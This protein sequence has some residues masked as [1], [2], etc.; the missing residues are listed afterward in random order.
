MLDSANKLRPGLKTEFPEVEWEGE[1][2]NSNGLIEFSDGTT[3]QGNFQNHKLKTGTLCYPNG[4]HLSGTFSESK[5][6]IIGLFQKGVFTFSNHVKINIELSGLKVVSAVMY[7]AKGKEVYKFQGSDVSIQTKDRLYRIGFFGVTESNRSSNEDYSRETFYSFFGPFYSANKLN[8]K[9]KS[10]FFND[11]KNTLDDSKKKAKYDIADLEII[12]KHGKKNTISFE[13]KC[14]IGSFHFFVD[15]ETDFDSAVGFY[16]NPVLKMN[17]NMVIQGKDLIFVYEKKVLHVKKLKNMIMEM[18][19]KIVLGQ[20]TNNI[21]SKQDPSKVNDILRNLIRDTSVDREHK[22][23]HDTLDAEYR[24]LKEEDE[25][26]RD[27]IENLK[28]QCED[29]ENKICDLNKKIDYQNKRDHDFDYQK[30]LYVQAHDENE[31][32]NEQI[33]KMKVTMAEEEEIKNRLQNDK[34]V[35]SDENMALISKVDE[36][37]NVIRGV[38][39]E[40]AQLST[41]IKNV[42]EQMNAEKVESEKIIKD[43]EKKCLVH[44]NESMRLMDEIN[45]LQQLNSEKELKFDNERKDYEEAIESLKEDLEESEA[46]VELLENDL[47][48]Y[49]KEIEGLEDKREKLTCIIEDIELE[50]EGKCNEIADLKK[51]DEIKEKEFLKMAKSNIDMKEKVAALKNEIEDLNGII[52]TI[53]EVNAENRK[54][55]EEKEIKMNQAIEMYK[56]QEKIRNKDIEDMEQ[57]FKSKI[58]GIQYEIEKYMKICANYKTALE[59]QKDV[60]ELDYFKGS[61]EN[62]NKHGEC[63][64]KKG[65]YHFVGIYNKGVKEGKGKE[66]NN[67]IILEGTFKADLL[68]GKG[69]YIDKAT[70]KKMEGEFSNGQFLGEKM[71]INKLLYTGGIS[72]NKMNGKGYF[73]FQNNYSYEGTFCKDEVEENSKGIIINLDTGEDISVVV[74]NGR[75]IEEDTKNVY[76]INDDTGKLVKLN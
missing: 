5:D 43:L 31:K 37:K 70:N 33:L 75:F 30:Q 4:A 48:G 66:I 74:S 40:N 14:F 11:F 34:A 68:E 49:R 59:K 36:L 28:V 21:D 3:L 26:K 63:E 19:N 23:M 45:K 44:I 17:L 62:G 8:K 46:A 71:T 57:D 35:L 38:A 16:K 39:Q 54:I 60:T 64:E 13:L 9:H 18:T 15:D 53:N 51:E 65:D 24:R 55:Y 32:L 73:E 12:K 20:N 67:N 29:Y 56:E 6:S 22:E 7:S 27:M 1:P 72:N 41:L 52:N 50:V 2:W 69:I 76:Y 61:F 42:K 58:D 10:F 25:L 47:K